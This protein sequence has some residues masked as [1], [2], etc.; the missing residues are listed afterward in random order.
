MQYY[1]FYY[2]VYYYYVIII[3]IIIIIA[4]IVTMTEMMNLGV[5]FL[6]G[7]QTL[8]ERLRAAVDDSVVVDGVHPHA[9]RSG[10]LR[11]R[12]NHRLLEAGVRHVHLERVELLLRQVTLVKEDEVLEEVL[13]DQQLLAL[14]PVFWFLKQQTQRVDYVFDGFG[15]LPVASHFIY[16][17]LLERRY[18]LFGCLV[19]GAHLQHNTQ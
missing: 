1:Y 10:R 13:P 18:G 3:T 8:D 14:L 2:Y 12:H 15:R 9:E 17:R 4:V 16:I 6:G 5:A 7:A 19:P 11:H